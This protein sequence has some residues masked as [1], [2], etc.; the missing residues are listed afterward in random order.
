MSLNIQ[1]L[2]PVQVSYND[3]PITRF[4]SNRVRALLFYLVAEGVGRRQNREM[5]QELLWPGMLPKSAQ[6]NLRQTLYELRKL[7]AQWEPDIPL[8]LSQPGMVQLN[9]DFPHVSD[10][11]EFEHLR[12]GNE[13]AQDE[14]VQLY[15]GAFLADFYLPDANPFEEWVASKRGLYQRQTLA[16]LVSLTEQKLGASDYV[17]AERYARRQLELDNLQEEAHRQLLRTL[18]HGGRRSEALQQFER[19]RTLLRRELGVAP[20]TETVMLRDQIVAGELLAVSQPE[21]YDD[22]EP[23]AAA[24]NRP[25]ISGVPHNLPQQPTQFLGREMELDALQLLFSK[26]INRLVTIIGPGGIG[27]TRLALAL[28]ERQLR[29]MDDRPQ[30]RDGIF[31]VGLAAISEPKSIVPALAEAVGYQLIESAD[32][33]PARDQ[34]LSYLRNKEMMIILDNFEHLMAGVGLIGEI[35]QATQATK[36]LVTSRE[37]LRLRTEQIYPLTG[38]GIPKWESV[39]QALEHSA[40]QLF[41]QSARR[42]RPEFNLDLPDLAYLAD[43]CHSV[44]GLP[45]AIE[46]AAAWVDK[47]G[48][49]DISSELKRGL[50]LLESELRDLPERQRSIRQTI[51]YSWQQLSQKEQ[52]ILAQLSSFRGSF[53]R[54]AATELA[55][56]DLPQLSRLVNKSLLQFDRER[57]RYLIHELL[58]QYGNEQ[59]Q[60]SGRLVAAQSAIARYFLRYVH[61]READIKGGRQLTAYEEIQ[62]ELPA[63]R[64]AWTWALSN[65][66]FDLVENALNA[67]IVFFELEFH[68]VSFNQLKQ[69]ALDAIAKSGKERPA[70][71]YRLVSWHSHLVGWRHGPN[72]QDIDLIETALRYAREEGNDSETVLCLDRLATAH[73]LSGKPEL[74]LVLIEEALL[75]ANQSADTYLVGRLLRTQAKVYFYF[76]AIDRAIVAYQESAMHD[77]AHGNLLGAGQQQLNLC[78][79]RFFHEGSYLVAETEYQ[80][81]IAFYQR[82]GR[83]HIVSYNSVMLGYLAFLRGDLTSA[84]EMA[85]LAWDGLKDSG[86]EYYVDHVH[87]LMGMLAIARQDYETATR[88]Y[89]A[90]LHLNYELHVATIL[91]AW[92]LSL[93]AYGL[94]EFSEARAQ[95]GAAL[96]GALKSN[97]FGVVGMV[98]PVASLLYCQK[99]SYER[100]VSLFALAEQTLGEMAGYLKKLSLFADLPAFLLA[101]CG[102]DVYAA[103]WNHGESLELI[104]TGRIVLAELELADRNNDYE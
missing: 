23:S 76:G 49:A 93:T 46:L 4:R 59:L 10:I 74:S 63:I 103:A 104:P 101:A 99:Q 12:H 64:R 1:L 60:L 42:N 75:L 73:I 61:R 30:L 25:V 26:P 89:R 13:A 7:G 55:G 87:I 97:R 66:Q 92:G 39:S 16:L 2:G 98:F 38:F 80:R 37:R 22:P 15:R 90:G 62:L 28:A 67:L 83:H 82:I 17:E 71:W 19:Y 20:S 18:Y 56:A 78:H 65:Q 79:A 84:A 14:A 34:I 57:K 81:M 72:E 6:A 36:I 11:H 47:I 44:G 91:R 29:S 33:Q 8:L 102:P 69:E 95:F 5:L 40:G 77:D 58:R 51:S 48:L 45:L 88:L 27:K 21:K 54:E 32:S 100:A 53:T 50:D 52:Q 9:P 24:I 41:L 31:F 3:D 43:I 70:L 68:L 94:G 96:N 85:E 35:L 86:D